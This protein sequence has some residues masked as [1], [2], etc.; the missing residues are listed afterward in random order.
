MLHS[1]RNCFL[2]FFCLVSAQIGLGQTE[3]QPSLDTTINPLAQ[4]DTTGVTNINQDTIPPV[5]SLS[6][7]LL[8][9]FNQPVPKKYRIADIKVTGNNY[10]DQNLLLS[11]ASLSVGDEVTLPGGDN[12]SKAIT[13]LWSQN[14]FS[15]IAIYLTSVKDDAI[16]V[17]V[18]V[19][20]RPRLSGFE[21]KGIK[22]AEVDDLSPKN[23]I[24]VNRVITENLKRTS[25]DAIKRFFADKGYRNADVSIQEI[26][27]SS[28]QNSSK[29]VF[30]ID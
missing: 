16:T 1:F 19:T 27:D 17:E 4:P 6:P 25:S 20:E 29:L 8:N 14:Y 2:F 5:T 15:D 30:V 11:I 26:A 28:A 12:F 23:G 10:F 9:I 7:D 21:F 13:K 22:K 24:V 3:T 18:N